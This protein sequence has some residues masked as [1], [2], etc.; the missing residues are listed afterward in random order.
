MAVR[1]QV[2][3]TPGAQKKIQEIL[4]YLVENVS[5]E[6]ALKVHAAIFDTIN[7]L[8][9]FPE[10]HSLAR[11]ISKKGRIYRRVMIMSY[12]VVYTVDK[13]Q[14]KVIVVDVDHGKRNKEHLVKK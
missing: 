14:S 3:V 9:T 11:S 5:V 2:S 8:N 6:I 4:S 7:A 1:Y 13:E 10:S 12:R